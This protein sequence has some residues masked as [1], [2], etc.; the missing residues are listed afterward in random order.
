VVA[1]LPDLGDVAVLP[2]LVVVAVLPEVGGTPSAVWPVV[3]AGEGEA[4]AL[5]LSKV[6]L[7]GA[8][9]LAITVAWSPLAIENASA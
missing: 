5:H 4:W 8:R 3:D 1:V 7:W 9:A 6:A 2:G